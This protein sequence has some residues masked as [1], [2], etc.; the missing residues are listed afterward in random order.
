MCGFGAGVYDRAWASIVADEE[1]VPCT[2]INTKVLLQT[3][4]ISH[5]EEGGGSILDTAKAKNDRLK[6]PLAL[7]TAAVFAGYF[8]ICPFGEGVDIWIGHA[9]YHSPTGQEGPRVQGQ[10][11]TEW[12]W[13]ADWQTGKSGRSVRSVLPGNISARTT[14]TIDRIRPPHTSGRVVQPDIKRWGAAYMCLFSLM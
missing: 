11:E 12:D 7:G 4:L 2:S 14:L 6:S 13:R 1:R 8:G 3:R 9:A 5:R 10:R